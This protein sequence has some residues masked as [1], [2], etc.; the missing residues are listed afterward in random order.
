MRIMNKTIMFFWGLI[1]FVIC[2]YIL[3]LGY[4]MKDK[5]YEAV[6]SQLKEASLAYAKDKNIELKFNESVKI[7]IDDLIN[8]EYIKDDELLDK[9]C[10]DSVIIQRGL[11]QDDYIFTK[12]CDKE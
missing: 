6:T 5:E 4:N 1:I 9:Y 8:D 11:I 10:I 3:F 12:D 2:G 7:F